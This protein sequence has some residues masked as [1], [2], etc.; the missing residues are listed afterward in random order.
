MNSPC[1][2]ALCPSIFQLRCVT[3]VIACVLDFSRHYFQMPSFLHSKN[4]EAFGPGS[5]PTALQI[6]SLSLFC[7]NS[8]VMAEPIKSSDGKV[9]EA[10]VVDIR[11]DG[12]TL[13]K[14]GIPYDVPWE[15]LDPDQ[16]RKIRMVRWLKV[17]EDKFEDKISAKTKE[18]GCSDVG[19]IYVQAFVT[20][21]PMKLQLPKRYGF[22]IVRTGDDWEWLTYHKVNLLL[23]DRPFGELPSTIETSTIGGG[24]VIE[25]VVTELSDEQL[26]DI[27]TA[28]KVE[29]RVGVQEF[30]LDK[31]QLA[32]LSALR[33]FF[34]WARGV[35]IR[36][37]TN[38]ALKEESKNDSLD[39][40]RD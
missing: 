10:E 39:D 11:A 3:S 19:S 9:I 16:A 2:F 29:M 31:D 5:L 8:S 33:E 22:W 17:E 18:L 28:K 30:T 27:C 26:A 36:N 1:L 21:K 34:E 6:L 4:A 24:R 35:A 25:M 13:K 12:V 23:D 32:G 7:L 38:D 14:S 20:I 15:K 40:Q 37:S